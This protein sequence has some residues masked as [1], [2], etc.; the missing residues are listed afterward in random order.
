MTLT[1]LQSRFSFKS[2]QGSSVYYFDVVVDAQSVVTVTNV[3]ASSSFGTRTNCS[4]PQSTFADVNDAVAL[5]TDLVA[6]SQVTS[7]SLIFT[8]ETSQTAVVAPGVLNNTDY[9][10][11]YTPPDAIYIAT[12]NKSTTGFDAVVA[13]AYGSLTTPL[14]VPYVVMVST[15]AASSYA[16]TLTFTVGD[17]GVIAVVFP[18]AMASATYRVVLS[19]E[20]FFDARVVNQTRNGFS[21]EIGYT[22]G[23]ADT[24]I[25][26]FDVFVG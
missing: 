24:A 2:V 1:R 15:F 8:G 6:E 13:A 21:V 7:G 11:V 4:L 18:V 26:G 17:A 5:V 16:G 9:R 25:V 23:I 20:G 14:T 10:V 22:L 19:P 3:Q 12:E